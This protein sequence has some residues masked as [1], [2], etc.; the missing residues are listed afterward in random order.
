LDAPAAHGRHP[1]QEDIAL[2]DTAAWQPRR[3]HN[4]AD[5]EQLVAVRKP[6]TRSNQGPQPVP[7]PTG[8]YPFRLDLAQV[9]GPAAMG[10][11]TSSGKLVLHCA[12]DT[13]GVVNGSAQQIVANHMDADLAA[14]DPPR[15]FYHLG[16]V[17]YF[18]GEHENYYGQFYE[19]YSLYGAPIVAI[20]GNHDGGVPPHSQ[21][22]SLSAFVENFCASAPHHTAEAGDNDRDAMTQPN[23]YWTLVTPFATFVGLYTNVPEGG[24]VDDDQRAWLVEELKAA[25]ADRALVV[26]LHHPIISLDDHHSG[27]TRMHE[28]VDGAS[29]EAGR[30]PD[31][32]LTAH[33]HNYQR[34]TR[35]WS[36]REVPFI[37]AGA[38][39]YHNLHYMTHNL[40]WPI[41]LPFEVPPDSANGLQATLEAFSDDHHGYLVLEFSADQIDGTYFTVPRPHEPWRAP[42]TAADAFSVDLKQHK[43]VKATP[44]TPATGG[45][46]GIG[47][48]SS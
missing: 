33:V 18:Y 27:S 39:G 24:F 4:S 35:Q 48:S 7:R 26:S 16:D 12:G 17:V 13:G 47:N 31:L 25:P 3:H 34:F 46:S 5:L 2:D 38:G 6:G 22:P 1:Q 20:P 8:Q 32:V 37:V 14:A 30:L 23:A 36:G 10:Q 42:A 29:E 44:R 19:P 43:L 9:L 40:G 15:F 45:V 28:L 41:S 11:I 21:D